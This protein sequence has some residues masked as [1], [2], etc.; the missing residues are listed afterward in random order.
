MIHYCTQEKCIVHDPLNEED[1]WL[2]KVLINVRSSINGTVFG[3]TPTT[4]VSFLAVHTRKACIESMHS[5]S[6]RIN[7]ILIVEKREHQTHNPH[8]V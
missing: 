4:M 1:F 5:V 7:H 3:H 8:H 2:K 6:S